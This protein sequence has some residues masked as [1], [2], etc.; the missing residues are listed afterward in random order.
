MYS[1]VNEA[2]SGGQEM[3]GDTLKMVG[4]IDENSL[5]GMNFPRQKFSLRT[6]SNVK[7]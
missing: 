6:I 1:M 4:S 5:W 3:M 7:A 2:N